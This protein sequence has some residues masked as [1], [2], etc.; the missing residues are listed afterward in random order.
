MLLQKQPRHVQSVCLFTVPSPPVSLSHRCTQLLITESLLLTSLRGGVSP[1]SHHTFPPL[2]KR[3]SSRV[4]TVTS[5][6]LETKQVVSAGA[7][8]DPLQLMMCLVEDVVPPIALDRIQSQRAELIQRLMKPQMTRSV[9]LCP[10]LRR[11]SG[12]PA[13]PVASSLLLGHPGW[14]DDGGPN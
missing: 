12:G 10:P 5:D 7:L 4:S 3:D 13:F 14:A 2:D 6:S 9:R 1:K 8:D 11:S